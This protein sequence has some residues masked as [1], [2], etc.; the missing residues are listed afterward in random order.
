V[1]SST[2]ADPGFTRDRVLGGRVIL[3]QPARG[4][5]V[6]IDPIFLAAAIEPGAGSRVLDLGCGVGAIG[7]C[8]L[9]RFPGIRVTGL[10]LN[11]ELAVLARRSVFENDNAGQFDIHLGSVAAPPSVITAGGFEVVATNPPYLEPGRATA[12][13]NDAKQAANMEDGADL[14]VWIKTAALALRHKGTLA[15]IHRADRLDH[16]LAVL[17]VSFGGITIHP[18]WAKAGTS[19]KRV[20]ILA[21]KGVSSVTQLQAGTVLHKSDGTFTDAA[22]AVLNGGSMAGIKIYKAGVTADNRPQILPS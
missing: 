12:S 21:R 14:E 18:L 20:I 22:Q 5:R 6:A 2:S 15:L 16:I 7:L 10:E 3:W 4:Y 1:N 19:A 8:L 17:R 11:P 9:A 13:P